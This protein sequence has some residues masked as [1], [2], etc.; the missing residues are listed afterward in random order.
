MRTG[1]EERHLSNAR[2]GRGRPFLSRPLAAN[3]ARPPLRTKIDF[4][5]LSPARATLSPQDGVGRASLTRDALANQ[6]YLKTKPPSG[7]AFRPSQTMGRTSALKVRHPIHA[8]ES[9]RPQRSDR[10]VGALARC[11]LPAPRAPPRTRPRRSRA[12]FFPGSSILLAV[13]RAARAPDRRAAPSVSAPAMGR[14]TAVV[15][16]HRSIV[17]ARAG[18][19]VRHAGAPHAHGECVTLGTGMRHPRNLRHGRSLRMTGTGT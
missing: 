16:N 17:S 15:R 18:G 7:T 1:R 2:E 11:A 19:W 5:D 9:I 12:S 4:A 6:L 13:H 10:D 8:I 14:D 3:A